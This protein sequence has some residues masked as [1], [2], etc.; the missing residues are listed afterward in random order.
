[1][2]AKSSKSD[3]RAGFVALVGEPNAGKSTLMNALIGERVSIVTP[4][5]QTTR[6]RVTGILSDEKAQ[7]V[8]VDS[9]GLIKS[10]SGLNTFLQDEARDVIESADVIVA[11]LAADGS[12]A[13]AKELIGS[14]RKSGKPFVVVVNKV[15][16]LKGTATPKFFSYLV[17]EHIPFFSISALKRPAEARDEVIR[18]VSPLLP[19]SPAPLYDDEIYTTQTLRELAGEAVR[20]AC[21]LN[22]KQEIPYG[23]AVRVREFKENDGPVVRIAAEIIIEKDNHKGI[24][25]GSKGAMLKKIGSEARARIEKFVQRQVYLELYAVVKP[26]W[27]KNKKLMEELGYVVKE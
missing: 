13:F 4:K 16:T 6:G 7:L 9:P 20:E 26:N 1:M 21:F 18:V 12:E 19:E 5:P 17:E 8:F 11:L 15:D 3:Y 14:L 25:I 2:S 27:F 23:L 22:L 10:T 24:V